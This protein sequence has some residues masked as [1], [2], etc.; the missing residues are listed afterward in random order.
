MLGM[1]QSLVQKIENKKVSIVNTNSL[2]NFLKYYTVISGYYASF[3]AYLFEDYLAKLE[4]LS[5]PVDRSL[6]DQDY[7][8]DVNLIRQKIEN[9][10]PEDFIALNE[11]K[12]SKAMSVEGIADK[13]DTMGL[14][15]EDLAGIKEDMLSEITEDE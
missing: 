14:A 1:D 6:Y 3:N 10:R 2:E 12:Q 4:V 5:I 15:V 11:S 13:L 9:L 7:D 8:F